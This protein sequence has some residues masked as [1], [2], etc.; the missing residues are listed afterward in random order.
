[1]EIRRPFI[2]WLI[3][4]TAGGADK[5]FDRERSSLPEQRVERISVYGNPPFSTQ[6]IEGLSELKRAYPYG[7]RLVQRYIRGIVESNADPSIGE[8]DGVVYCKTI[9][10]EG[11]GVAPNRFAAFLV[12]RAVATRKLHGFQ[13]WRCRR[14]ALGSL[15]RELHA[16]RLL[17][18]EQKYFHQ[19]LNKI[20][21]LEKGSVKGKTR[22]EVGT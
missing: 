6:V 9:P 1:V 18:C 7:Y 12:R 5:N 17:Q 8:S 11:L 22:E 16:M 10:G 2:R 14:S 19:Q 21:K 4:A 20:L 13:I 3:H 15:N